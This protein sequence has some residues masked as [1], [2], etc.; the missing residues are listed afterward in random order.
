M[1]TIYQ[2]SVL[3]AGPEAATFADQ[4]MLVLFGENAPD[5]LKEFCYFI[6]VNPVAG[7]IVPGCTF[8][9]NDSEYE[10]TAVGEVAQQNLA[11]LGHITLVFNG[12]IKPHLPGAINLVEAVSVPKLVPGD[13][14]RITT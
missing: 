13:V 8:L 5:M 11:N 2:T 12:A 3:G 6:D 7:D 4:N 1:T 14:L 9:I 10:I